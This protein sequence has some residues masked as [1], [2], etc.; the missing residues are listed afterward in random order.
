[1]LQELEHK[2][3]SSSEVIDKQTNLIGFLPEDF[4]IE[5]KEDLRRLLVLYVENKVRLNERM[6]GILNTPEFEKDLQKYERC[7]MEFTVNECENNKCKKRSYY[8][9][10][11]K[12]KFC[13]Y[14]Y[15]YLKFKKKDEYV[16]LLKNCKIVESMFDRG[17]RFVTLTIEKIYG[18]KDTYDMINRFTK[19][20]ERS[21]YFKDKFYSTVGTTEFIPYTRQYFITPELSDYDTYYLK[22]LNCIFSYNNKTGIIQFSSLVDLDIFD[23]YMLFKRIDSTL[24]NKTAIDLWHVH[25]HLIADSKYIPMK[26]EEGEDSEFVKHWKKITKG[27]SYIVHVRKVNNIEKDLNYLLG[28][29]LKGISHMDD[30][31]FRQ[32]YSFIKHKKLSFVTGEFRKKKFKK[33]KIP[34]KCISCGSDTKYVDSVDIY[35]L[36][37][38]L[39]ENPKRELLIKN[40][41]KNNS[42][43]RRGGESMK[44]VQRNL[45]GNNLFSS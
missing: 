34:V 11:C 42:K 10:S 3:N 32:Y 33:E 14:C 26:H 43:E 44:D 8:P 6:K 16:E 1:M 12:K 17:L 38:I 15:Q 31:S 35:R 5:T 30:E 27:S 2:H 22:Q 7:R 19:R 25:K 37:E 21:E 9:K 36:I 13:E 39:E 23:N 41:V 45:E 24:S 29:S 28:Y 4:D 40:F 18:I 20:L